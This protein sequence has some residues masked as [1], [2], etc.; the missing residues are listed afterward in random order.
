MG[1]HSSFGFLIL[2]DA[3]S[4]LGSYSVY[5]TILASGSG[6]VVS[7]LKPWMTD[8]RDIQNRIQLKEMELKEQASQFLHR[9][10]GAILTL[11]PNDLRGSPPLPDLV[12]DHTNQ[13]FRTVKVLSEFHSIEACI[14]RSYSALL[15]LV[16]LS[17]A[18]LLTSLVFEGTRP[19]IG[20]GS[21]LIIVLE[22]AVVAAI[23]YWSG[24]LRRYEKTA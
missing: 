2:A 13:I 14:R 24:Q 3:W 20:L 21:A 17:V 16:G 19:F 15:F 8:E 4:N 5:A 11:E 23:R 18:S 6:A 7:Y 10:L 22:F 1:T 9:A 12:G